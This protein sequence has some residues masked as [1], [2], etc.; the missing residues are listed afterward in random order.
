M[1]INIVTEGKYVEIEADNFITLCIS[2]TP[3]G[4]YC[5]LELNEPDVLIFVKD[6]RNK[7][8]KMIINKGILK[9][10]EVKILNNCLDVSHILK[11]VNVGL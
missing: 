10:V 11:Y 8:N 7:Y 2:S 9:G 6:N 3:K 5:S 1:D 4:I